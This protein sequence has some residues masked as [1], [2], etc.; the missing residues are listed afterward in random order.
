MKELNVASS[1]ERL[2]E[3][4]D[5]LGVEKDA[6]SSESLQGLGNNITGEIIGATSNDVSHEKDL[7]PPQNSVP[8][9]SD[10]HAAGEDSKSSWKMVLHEESNSYYYWNT[11]TGETSWEVPADLAQVAAPLVSEP[12]TSLAEDNSHGDMNGSGAI[13]SANEVSYSLFPSG[14]QIPLSTQDNKGDECQLISAPSAIDAF[15]QE[16]LTLGNYS[17]YVPPTDP[18]VGS[19]VATPAVSNLYAH[20]EI[21]V[22][23]LPSRL[24]RRSESLLE[25]LRS[26][27][28]YGLL[29]LLFIIVFSM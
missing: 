21:A 6:A 3:K 7:E 9:A 27:R 25:K 8:L 23:D 17:S 15:H 10:V 12:Q 4:N 5:E 14:S 2:P 11:V 24:V 18:F 1:E 13:G 20:G 22:A 28:G 29:S 16:N 19:W 26:L